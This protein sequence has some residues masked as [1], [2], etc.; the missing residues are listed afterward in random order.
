MVW[1]DV[2]FRF[3]V[4][5]LHV[6]NE[7]VCAGSHHGGAAS[8][9]SEGA[10]DGSGLP[11]GPHKGPQGSQVGSCLPI[12]CHGP[13]PGQLPGCLHLPHG[14]CCCQKVDFPFCFGPF[15]HL[16]WPFLPFRPFWT[17]FPFGPFCHLNTAETVLVIAI[18]LLQRSTP[19]CSMPASAR[20]V[21][22]AVVLCC[23]QGAKASSVSDSPVLQ[24][25]V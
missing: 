11:E 21:S 2:L 3:G 8:V 1:V 10:P 13:H 23:S 22:A 20:V 6:C 17:S 7:S 4:F 19:C 5:T 25:A 9:C 18:W 16:L 12:G 14:V 15:C 24:A